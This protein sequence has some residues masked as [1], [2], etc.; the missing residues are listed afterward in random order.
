LLL[1]NTKYAGLITAKNTALT[2]I[3]DFINTYS[4][5]RATGNN[6]KVSYNNYKGACAGSNEKEMVARLACLLLFLPLLL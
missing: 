2:V 5:N 3:L 1:S 4:Y 6:V